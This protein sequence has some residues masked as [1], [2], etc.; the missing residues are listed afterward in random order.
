MKFL[1]RRCADPFG[2][3]FFFCPD[4]VSGHGAADKP[5]AA[6]VMPHTTAFSV[7]ICYFQIKIAISLTFHRFEKI[8][9]KK[10]PARKNIKK[11]AA[12]FRA[13]AHTGNRLH[14]KSEN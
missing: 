13:P 1:N 6:G 10:A 4:A 5:R 8:S 2:N 11:H 12:E 9:H 14:P 3:F 7:K